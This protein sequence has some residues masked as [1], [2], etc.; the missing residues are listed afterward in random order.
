MTRTMK[1]FYTNSALEVAKWTCL[2]AIAKAGLST[3]Y[4]LQAD[5]SLGYGLGQ[6]IRNCLR[7]D[8]ACLDDDSR[9]DELMDTAEEIGKFVAEE[10]W[11]KGMDELMDAEAARRAA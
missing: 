10:G 5:G 11:I 4:L 9:F 3:K 7:E 8:I 2:A 1:R 6:S